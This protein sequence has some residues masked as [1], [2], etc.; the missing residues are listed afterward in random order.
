MPIWL[1][2]LTIARTC[3]FIYIHTHTYLCVCETLCVIYIYIYTHTYT[4]TYYRYIYAH[5]FYC[6]CLGSFGAPQDCLGS[7][8][9][10][11]KPSVLEVFEPG[12]GVTAPRSTGSASPEPVLST[13]FGARGCLALPSSWFFQNCRMANRM[14]TGA[15]PNHK[16]H[17]LHLRLKWTWLLG[18]VRTPSNIGSNHRFPVALSIL[19]LQ[20]MRFT[21]AS[22]DGRFH[23][24]CRFQSRCIEDLVLYWVVT[25][26]TVPQLANLALVG[27]MSPKDSSERAPKPKDTTQHPQISDH[28]ATTF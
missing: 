18:L 11:H 2:I 23:P 26:G 28:S 12:H 10:L 21:G 13:V 16:Y 14:A 6:L 25:L 3:V 19:L 5:T 1:E 17:S 7:Y 22:I 8:L 20:D 24:G 27:P 15:E 9:G 4:C